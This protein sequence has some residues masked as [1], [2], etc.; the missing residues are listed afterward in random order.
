MLGA[1]TGFRSETSARISRKLKEWSG[2]EDVL[3]GEHPTMP[4]DSATKILS[5]LAAL[6]QAVKSGKQVFPACVH[7]CDETRSGACSV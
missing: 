7:F 1:L 4:S 2:A 3:K 5:H 6:R